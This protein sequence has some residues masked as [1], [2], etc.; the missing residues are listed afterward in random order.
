MDREAVQFVNRLKGK[1]LLHVCCEAE[2][3]DFDFAP[4][5]LHAMGC[6]RVIK[7]NDILVTTLDYQ[8]WDLEEST[9][10]DECFNVERF[11]SEIVGGRVVSVAVSPCH[12]LSI[13]LDNH[14]VIEC[15]I[16]NAYPHYEEEQEQWV[17]FEPT[18]DHS[19]AFLTVYNKHSNFHDK[20][21]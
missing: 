6:S 15:R 21:V 4:L 1:Q 7:N 9:H 16:A 19:G 13:E 10:N 17:L 8:S 11:Y 5:A 18:K 3:L 12:D 14:V 20:S 2:I